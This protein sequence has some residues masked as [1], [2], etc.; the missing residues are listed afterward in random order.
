M[1]REDKIPREYSENEGG[2]GEI[3][4]DATENVRKFPACDTNQSILFV[5]LFILKKRKQIWHTDKSLLLL[6]LK[7]INEKLPVSQ[8]TESEIASIC[9]W[10]CFYSICNF[11]DND[12]SAVSKYWYLPSYK[13]CASQSNKLSLKNASV[14]FPF[15]Q[16]KKR[17]E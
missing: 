1:E 3:Q 7:I 8:F 16:S 2:E 10:Q 17:E 14:D 4:L 15:F 12:V 5:C 11:Q 9:G 13:N 6:F